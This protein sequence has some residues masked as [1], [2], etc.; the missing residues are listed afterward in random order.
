M[1][2]DFNSCHLGYNLSVWCFKARLGIDLPVQD[3]GESKMAGP[4]LAS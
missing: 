4:K 1:K 2:S 3:V